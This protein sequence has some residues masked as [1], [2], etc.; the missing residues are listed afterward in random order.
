MLEHAVLAALTTLSRTWHLGRD[1]L[2]AWTSSPAESCST[3]P[4]LSA[5]CVY[6]ETLGLAIVREWGT[7]RRRPVPTASPSIQ[8]SARLRVRRWRWPADQRTAGAVLH[9]KLLFVDGRRALVGSA[10]LTHLL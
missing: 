6:G 10:T 4:T 7:P 9:A 1:P 2:P 8:L 3:P 5:R